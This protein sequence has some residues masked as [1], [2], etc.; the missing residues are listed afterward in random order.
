MKPMIE[1]IYSSSLSNKSQ[2]LSHYN[3]RQFEYNYEAL[4]IKVDTSGLYMLPT[5]SNLDTSGYL[6]EHQFDPY[7][8]FDTSFDRDDNSGGDN[9]FTMTTYLQFNITYVLVIT[10]SYYS[11]NNEGPFSVIVEGSDGIEMKR[12]GMFIY[13]LNLK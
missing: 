2:K 6:Y 5:K 4:K 3:C 8:F 10:T 1:S 7:S 12:M 13:K 11:T 9:Q